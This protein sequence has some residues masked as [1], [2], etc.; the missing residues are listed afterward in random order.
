MSSSDEDTRP[1]R[2]EDVRGAGPAP[3]QLYARVVFRERGEPQVGPLG[4]PHWL[5]PGATLTVGRRPGSGGVALPEDEWASRRHARLSARALGARQAV[6]VEDL[7]SSNGTFVDGRVASGPTLAAPGAVVRVGST[8]LVVGEAPRRARESL[9]EETPPPPGWRAGSWAALSLWRRLVKVAAT[10]DPVLLL[11]EPGSGKTHLAQELHRLSDRCDG[12][13]VPLNASAIPLNLEEATLFGVVAGFL[14]GVDRKIGLLTQADGGTLFLDELADMPPLAQAKLL[15]AFDPLRASYLP[16][17]ASARLTTGCRLVCATNQDV[18][19]LAARGALRQD[20]LS[21]L[22]VGRLDVPPLRQ[23]REDVM[24]LFA[25]ALDRFGVARAQ[26]RLSAEAAEALLLARWAENVRGLHSLV[27]QISHGLELTAEAIR[28][29]ADRGLEQ[30]REDE[31]PGPRA[32]PTLPAL[33]PARP[34]AWP[35]DPLQLLAL[36]SHHGWSV[37]AVA[38]AVGRRRET[39]GR[40]LTRTFGDGGRA[41]AQRAFAVWQASGRLPSPEQTERLHAL[42]A[43]PSPDNREERRAWVDRGEAPGPRVT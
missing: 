29:H 8:L 35:P 17:G 11:G 19:A 20:L 38:E 5:R 24:A 15:D 33:D 10:E 23:R 13:F 14:P 12:P 1:R 7:G 43:A 16:V 34:P 40:L 21:R 26:A 27:R 4:A 36:L 42:F 31:E 2:P 18:F 32:A 9:L 41:A 3:R 30:G 22:V 39:V 28:G 6:L 37:Q 25:D